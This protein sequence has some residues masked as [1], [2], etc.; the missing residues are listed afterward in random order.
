MDDGLQKEGDDGGPQFPVSEVGAEQQ[1]PFIHFQGFPEVL[2]AFHI[3]AVVHVLP[4]QVLYVRKVRNDTAEM[5]AHA[6]GNALPF[7]EGLVG[8]GALEVV[9]GDDP[10]V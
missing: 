5:P 3:D 8:E 7:T 6:A 4:R 1:D 9:Q 10:V 2:D